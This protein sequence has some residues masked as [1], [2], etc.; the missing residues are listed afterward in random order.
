[1][2]NSRED[3]FFFS[4]TMYTGEV[5]AFMELGQAIGITLSEYRPPLRELLMSKVDID[6]FVDSGAFSEVSFKTG[7]REV[8]KPISHED[9]LLK[10]KQY[11]ELAELYGKSCVVVAPDAVGDQEESLH[12]VQRYKDQIVELLDICEVI[13]P[14]QK[15]ALSLSDMYSQIQDTLSDDRI[16][17]GIPMKK[18]AVSILEY[19]SFLSHSKPPRVHIL[20]VSKA[21]KK[22]LQVNLTHRILK[23]QAPKVSHDACRITPIVGK[24]RA[25]TVA[26]HKRK[27][28]E[29]QQAMYESLLEVKDLLLKE[30]YFDET[31]MELF[32]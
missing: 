1:M 10:F 23:D 12:R 19:A 5:R 11:T 9:W 14:I 7:Q 25:L 6:L 28:L 26:L 16:I 15:G 22:W 27:H 31:Q 2:Y 18:S 13:V 24:G 8:V 32:I 3:M 4:G 29:R 21:S 30:A 20:G 17:A